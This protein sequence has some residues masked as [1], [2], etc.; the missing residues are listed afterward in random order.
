M[1]VI[2]TNF[3]K[4]CRIVQFLPSRCHLPIRFW[5]FLF[6]WPPAVPFCTLGMQGNQ[7]NFAKPCRTEQF[8]PSRCHLPIGFWG[9]LFTWPPAVSFCTSVLRIPYKISCILCEAIKSS[10]KLGV[11][12]KFFRRITVN[13]LLVLP[14]GSVSIQPNAK[15]SRR[16]KAKAW[17]SVIL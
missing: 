3:A 2:Q 8:L 5:G 12:T 15:H 1:Q 11:A 9:F 16:G 4:P 6:T 10:I 13:L 14:H 7:T 17:G